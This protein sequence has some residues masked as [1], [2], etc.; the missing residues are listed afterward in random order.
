MVTKHGRRERKLD[1]LYVANERVPGLPLRAFAELTGLAP[2]IEGKPQV[3]GP[4]D[5]IEDVELPPIR[6]I[7]FRQVTDRSVPLMHAKLALLGHTL[8]A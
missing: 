2:K 5:R 6:T 8:V 4:Y 1:R 7:G 3:V